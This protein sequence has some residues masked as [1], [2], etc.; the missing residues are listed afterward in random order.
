MKRIRG[1]ESDESVPLALAYGAWERMALRPMLISA[2]Q[3]DAQSILLF[4]QPA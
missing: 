1:Q 4:P 3:F 2:P